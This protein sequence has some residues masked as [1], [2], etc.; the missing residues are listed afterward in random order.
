[1]DPDPYQKSD[2][3]PYHKGRVH[4]ATTSS[5]IL[6][7]AQL[8]LLANSEPYSFRLQV[9]NQGPVEFE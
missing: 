4:T 7:G 9:M 5:F 1:M 2:P 8:H 6:R 3:D